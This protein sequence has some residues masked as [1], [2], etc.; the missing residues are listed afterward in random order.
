MATEYDAAYFPV[1]KSQP[2]TVAP[3]VQ[4]RLTQ[5]GQDGWQLAWISQAGTD[6]L[7]VVMSRPVPPAPTP[8][9]SLGGY[10]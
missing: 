7:L 4:T 6:G 2:D 8:T 1:D 9:G 10:T 3:A 5:Q